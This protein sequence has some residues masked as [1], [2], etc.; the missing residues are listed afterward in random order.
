M[1]TN[2]LTDEIWRDVPGW[3][4]RY[5]IS[6][7]GRVRT[8]YIDYGNQTGVW[9]RRSVHRICTIPI[10]P[11]GYRYLRLSVHGKTTTTGV[12]QLV[13]QAFVSNPCGYKEVN[14]RNGIKHDNRPENLEW[15]SHQGNMVHAWG[16]G[17]MINA[18]LTGTKHHRAKIDDDVV[19]AIRAA[20]PTFSDSE[21]KARVAAQYGVSIC[22][23]NDILK[24][25]SW[26]HIA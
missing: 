25:R 7:L 14:H 10:H 8:N 16:A 17:L 13:A 21:T 24:R 2:H 22:T 23:V 20:V 9:Y 6:T 11:K 26:K 5:S 1:A 12:H 15:V 18:R 3:E 19:R 4:G